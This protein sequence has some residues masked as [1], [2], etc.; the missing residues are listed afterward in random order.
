MQATK[1]GVA[2]SKQDA[3][4][5]LASASS[6][7]P[8]F[9]PEQVRSATR[10]NPHDFLGG[11]VQVALADPAGPALRPCGAPVPM[12]PLERRYRTT[13]PA[14]PPLAVLG[15]ENVAVAPQKQIVKKPPPKVKSIKKAKEPKEPKGTSTTASWQP[16]MM[17]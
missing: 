14:A 12:M 17:L 3:D 13:A 10:A 4:E 7:L 15:K 9:T 11:C 5:R 16:P 6:I 8:L 2:A 1:L